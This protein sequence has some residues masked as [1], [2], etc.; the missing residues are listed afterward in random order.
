M[1]KLKLMEFKTTKKDIILVIAYFNIQLFEIINRLQKYLTK[2]TQMH[3]SM[4][5]ISFQSKK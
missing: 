1:D 5:K 4:F 2:D 3:G